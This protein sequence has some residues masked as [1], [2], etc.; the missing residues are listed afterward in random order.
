LSI[1]AVALG[2]ALLAGVWVASYLLARDTLAHLDLP[3]GQLFSPQDAE[4]KEASKLAVAALNKRLRASAGKHEKRPWKERVLVLRET[5]DSFFADAEIVSTLT[6]ADAGGV[7]AEWVTAPG[8]D[9]SRRFLYIHGGA[10]F[11][12]SP[13]SHRIL[14]SKLSEITNSAVLAIDYRLTPEHSRMA[15]VEDCRTSYD[16]MLKNSPEGVDNLAPTAVFVAGDSAGGNLTLSLLNWIRDNHRRAPNAA[17][18][19]SPA[20]DSRFTSPSIRTNLE[21]DVMLKPLAKRVSWLPGFLFS[22]GGRYM[23]GRGAS[24][25]VMSPLLAD[26]SGLPPILV[27]CSECEILRDDGRRYVNKAVLAGTDARL[28]RWNNVP[29]VWQIFH[30]DLPEAAQAFAEID[31]FFQ[32]HS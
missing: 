6:P 27:Q 32:R 10:F 11:A 8:V 25:P 19:L 12:G 18:A 14:T 9:K 30:P 15:C 2:L 1:T 28:Q 29:H 20:T 26:L 31:A 4:A 21:S 7:P 23:S 17:L 5:M 22:L 16:W 3:A 13:K 24:D